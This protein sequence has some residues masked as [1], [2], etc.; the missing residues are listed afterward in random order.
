MPQ[1]IT[2]FVLHSM[3]NRPTLS[4]AQADIHM[5]I[6]IHIKIIVIKANKTVI[7]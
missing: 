6:A 7:F 3:I 1:A 4:S 2:I 5:E